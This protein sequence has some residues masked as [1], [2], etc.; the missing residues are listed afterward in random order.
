[1]YIMHKNDRGLRRLHMR[2]SGILLPISSLPSRYGIGCLSK[3]AY[4]F[5][6]QLK[7]AGQKYW[8]I[9]PIGPTGY[10]DSPYQSFSTFA[11]NPYFID[12]ESL[13]EQEL[14]TR[15]ECDSTPCGTN[16]RYV[17]YGKIYE[18]RNKLLHM[19]YERVELEEL[20]GFAE[21]C[22]AEKEWLDDYV[23][24]RAV[25]DFFD[26][27]SFI[28]WA[29][30]IRLRTPRA[31]DRYKEALKEDIDYYSYV[32]FEFYKQ[33]TKLKTYASENGIDIV[34]DIPIYVAFDSADTWANPELFQFDEEGLPI[35][36]AGCPPDGFCATGQLWGNPLYN[37]GY[38]KETGYAW[39]IKRIAHCYRLYDVVRVDHF[40]GFDEYYAIP[41]GNETAEIGEWEP[42]PGI[43][44]FN[45]L[46]EAL[47][48][49][50][51]I[52]EDLG[53]LTQSVLDLVEESGY[54]GMK[55]LQFA[56]YAGQDDNDYRPH[57]HIQNSVVY[58]GTHDNTTTL[59]WYCSMADW[60]R[61]V[62]HD[63]LGRGEL[64]GD[65]RVWTF[66]RMAL[67][68]VADTCIIP[69]QDYLCL[70]AEARLNAPSSLGGGNWEWRV[71]P[72]EIRPE[73]IEKIAHACWIY[74]RKVEK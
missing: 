54:P 6:D 55:V 56:F 23:L 31:M 69:M 38:H 36:V 52:A 42:G 39:W 13:I 22:E 32:Q 70:G 18:A 49:K 68:S 30:D 21:F 10:G 29:D 24:Y 17:D 12:L 15:E 61:N 14:L 67:A 4:T 58:T 40:R 60:D 71:L 28:D 46:K 45:A 34:G 41:Y 33:W 16:P 64:H 59:D 74:A 19:A 72:D 1:M 43:D 27:K 63:Y 8:Q 26:G 37:W 51:V 2:A 11:G 20:E 57:N 25:K 3:E 53:F 50:P 5:V 9:L 62:V 47:G 66:I 48:D 44:I 73:L 35:G 7:Q 65:D